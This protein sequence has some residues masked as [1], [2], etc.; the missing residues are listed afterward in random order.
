MCA[1]H[2]RSHEVYRCV[3]W[4]HFI[5]FEY[6]ASRR[7]SIFPTPNFES[8]ASDMIAEAHRS[9]PNPIWKQ[10]TMSGCTKLGLE[11]PGTAKKGCAPR[12]NGDGPGRAVRQIAEGEKSC[13]SWNRGLGSHRRTHTHTCGQDK[14]ILRAAPM[15]YP[16][17]GKSS[18]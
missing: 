17:A 12:L 5:N 14:N 10:C 16:L 3:S 2:Q 6:A 7:V 15:T 9:W 8:L 13:Q 18:G 4:H 1:L 11:P